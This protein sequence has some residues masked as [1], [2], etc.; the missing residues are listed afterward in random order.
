[1]ESVSSM[2]MSSNMKGGMKEERRA[3][4][5]PIEMSLEV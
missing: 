3:A 5:A 4:A 1:M 2:S